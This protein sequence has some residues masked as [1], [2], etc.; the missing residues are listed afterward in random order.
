MV[1]SWLMHSI[2]PATSRSVDAIEL[3]L[4]LYMQRS[5]REILSRRYDEGCGV[6]L[7]ISYTQARKFIYY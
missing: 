4:D 1:H 3:A 6:D 2:S 7:G 5:Q